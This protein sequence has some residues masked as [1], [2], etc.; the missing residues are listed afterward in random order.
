MPGIINAG[1]L[2][3]S[4]NPAGIDIYV[5]EFVRAIPAFDNAQERKLHE[6]AAAKM[7]SFFFGPLVQLVVVLYVLL[8]ILKPTKLTK[9]S[10]QGSKT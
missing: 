8:L 3:L 10:V 7:A 4:E 5:E 2:T 9:L 1:D 6:K